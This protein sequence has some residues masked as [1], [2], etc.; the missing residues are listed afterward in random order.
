VRL[1]SVVDGGDL[2]EERRLLICHGRHLR[3]TRKLS[4]SASVIAAGSIAEP[5]MSAGALMEADTKLLRLNLLGVRRGECNCRTDLGREQ[6]GYEL[7]RD[8][9]LPSSP[10]RSGLPATMAEV[11][12]PN[13]GDFY[14]SMIPNTI[15]GHLYITS[16][17]CNKEGKS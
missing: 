17:A 4:F 14:S 1:E 2:R 9:E 8:E 15:L 11:I 3:E 16:D 12:S 6:R 7:K 10:R 5:G 13:Q